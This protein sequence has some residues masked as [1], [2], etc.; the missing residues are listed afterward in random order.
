MQTCKT[1]KR[2]SNV[3]KDSVFLRAQYYDT[4]PQGQPDFGAAG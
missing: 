4:C 1:I 2:K 3:K